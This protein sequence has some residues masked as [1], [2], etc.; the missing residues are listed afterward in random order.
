MLMTAAV[1]AAAFALPAMAQDAARGAVIAAERGCAACHGERGASTMPMVPSLAGQRADFTALQLI[2]FREGLRQ[3]PPMIEPARGLTD[4]DVEA[5]AAYF[6][7]QPSTSPTDRGPRDASL[8]EAGARLAAARNCNAC[9]MPDFS[10]RNQIP[11]INHQR[12]DFLAHTLVEYRDS[13]RVGTDTQMNGVMHGLS[14]PEIAA[15][16]HYLSHL[17]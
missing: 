6:A 5:L 17:D 3:V 15:I 4:A 8:M 12:E 1:L 2:L 10:G 13:V 9:H 14:D 11:R 7:A 16:A